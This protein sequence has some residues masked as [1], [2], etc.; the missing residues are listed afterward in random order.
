M[1]FL[2]LF[3]IIFIANITHAKQSINL[4]V[5][6]NFLLPAKE[7]ATNFEKATQYKVIISSGS[8]RSIFTKILNG[9][10]YDIFLSA[11]ID[12]IRLLENMN[13]AV[14]GSRFTY[15]KGSLVFYSS[16]RQNKSLKEA[17]LKADKIAIAN[18]K[19]A[20]YGVAAIDLLKNLDIL[21]QVEHKL[22]QGQNVAQAF[23]YAYSGNAQ[24]AIISKSQVAHNKVDT[25]LINPIAPKFYQQIEQQA[26]LL[27]RAKN[28]KAAEAF[29]NFLKQ[30][31]SKKIIQFYGYQAN[32]T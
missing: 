24:V 18:P 1:K 12:T 30:K 20:P 5:A 14:K 6:S 19:F 8:T 3:S 29:L 4:A 9:A 16:I 23:Q 7:L 15:A 27:I 11:D 31:E 2:L 26:A 32:D 22:I 21:E 28:N 10:P 17:L 13:F 25:N